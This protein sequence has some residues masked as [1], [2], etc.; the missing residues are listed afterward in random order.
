MT[1]LSN[2][3]IP[4]KRRNIFGSNPP[5]P[6]N[7]PV[8]SKETAKGGKI[9]PHQN[10]EVR[11]V[12]SGSKPLG[13]VERLKDPYGYALAISMSNVG[14]LAMVNIPGHDG[15][16]IFTKPHNQ[17]L[18][19]KYFHLIRDG[20]DMYGLKEYHRKL[21]KLF[22]YT[23]EDI[24]EYINSDVHCQCNKCNPKLNKVG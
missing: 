7:K 6:A 8:L 5:P 9:A 3:V 4:S 13:V 17:H 15:E 11:L 10:C 16:V 19:G 14:S 1:R 18:I 12:M 2:A 20:V 23:D 24:E 21:G 22:G